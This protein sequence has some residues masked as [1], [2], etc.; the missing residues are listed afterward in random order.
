MPSETARVT[1]ISIDSRNTKGENYIMNENDD[2]IRGIAIGLAISA[3]MWFSGYV[4]WRMV[5]WLW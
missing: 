5:R 3:A 2:A 4:A 1:P